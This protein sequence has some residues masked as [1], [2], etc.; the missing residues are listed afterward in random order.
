MNKKHLY[1]LSGFCASHRIFDLLKFPEDQFEVHYLPW[2]IPETSNESLSFYAKKYKSLIQEPLPILIGVSFGGM[3]VQEISKHV[4]CEKI[5]IISSVKSQK[6]FP[7]YLKLL[8]H[9]KAYKLFPVSAASQLENY[10]KFMIGKNAKKWLRLYKKYM[11][12]RDKKYIRWGIAQVF[13]WR[14]EVAPKNLLQI[15]GTEDLLFPIQKINDCISVKGGSHIMIITK[16]KIINR[17]LN[18]ELI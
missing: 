4:A 17:I 1:F 7:W 5:I 18:E 2:L 10:S 16:L 15:H 8:K 12:I 3:V 11:V 9:S 14:Q 6:E 13:E